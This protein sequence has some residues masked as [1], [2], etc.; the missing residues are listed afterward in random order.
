[1]YPKRIS[2]DIVARR[3][4]AAKAGKATFDP[5]VPCHKGHVSERYVVSKGCIDC[6]AERNGG[7]TDSG[8]PVR[9]KAKRAR[10]LAK[11]AGSPRYDPREPCI[12]GHTSDRYTSSNV[13]IQCSEDYNSRNRVPLMVRSARN[14]ALKAGR[15]FDLTEEHIYEIW[16]KDNAC[17]VFGKPF[18]YN[19]T[20]G[21]RND[22]APSLDRLDSSKG[23]TK[24]NVRIISWRANRI[25]NDGTYEEIQA[26]ANWMRKEFIFS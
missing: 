1:M 13:C 3:K 12:K 24:G 9:R 22:E 6:A 14:R 18:F 5:G 20:R 26:V 11:E 16:P 25:K 21:Q 19:L 4:A 23:Y 7:K 17:P 2:R 8:K 15:D 10:H